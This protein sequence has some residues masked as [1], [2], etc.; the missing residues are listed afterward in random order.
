MNTADAKTG[1]QIILI[2]EYDGTNY[3][4]SQFQ[5]N[6]PTI[7]GETEKAL[8]K[9]TGKRTRIKL[10]SRTDAG[11]HAKGQV[12]SFSAANVLPLKSYTDGLN[13]YLPDDI[14]VRES[15]AA[16][17]SFDPRRDA[18]SREYRYT[19]VNSPVRSPLR[20]R[21]SYRIWGQLDIPAM[22]QACQVLVGKRD[23]A[24][25]VTSA[26][27]A[28]IKRTVRNVYRAEVKQDADMITFDIVADSF[29]PHQVRN[30]VGSLIRV[31]QGRMTFAE[32]CTMI[33]ARTPGLAG[34]AVP[35]EGLCLMRVN[36]PGP[37]GRQTP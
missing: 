9:L 27:T 26:E 36:Y 7:Q 18:V 17:N 11:V 32:F 8:R 33:E 19:L 5:T 35:A 29:L 31:G 20:S 22:N 28:K 15:L 25:F 24:S 2:L 4:G 21:F 1:S 12:A 23:L 3:H 13:H 37:L 14:A 10:A 34:Q 16:E 6:A 30:M